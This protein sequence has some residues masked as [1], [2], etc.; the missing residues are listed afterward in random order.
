MPV[1]YVPTSE[2]EQRLNDVLA[3]YFEASEAG[4]PVDRKGLADLH[5]DLAADLR[6]FFDEQDHVAQV[7]APLRTVVHAALGETP[8]P[9]AQTPAGAGS[10]A[11]APLRSFGDY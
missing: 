2:R 7:A 3:A 10:D 9:P 5:P 6:R 8:Q 1:E 4:W 11:A